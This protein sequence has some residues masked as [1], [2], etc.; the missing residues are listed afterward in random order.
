[1][2]NQSQVILPFEPN[3]IDVVSTKNRSLNAQH[4]GNVYYTELVQRLVA[5]LPLETENLMEMRKIAHDIV[6][7][8]VD[9]RGGR[10]LKPPDGV[11]NP[12]ECVEMDKR[13]A[14][15]KVLHAIRTAHIRNGKNARG[16][17]FSPKTIGV[18]KGKAKTAK[19]TEKKSSPAVP[20]KQTKVSSS[21]R[22]QGPMFRYEI[23]QEASESSFNIPIYTCR[24]IEAVCNQSTPQ[25]AHHVLDEPLK[26]TSVALEEGKDQQSETEEERSHRLDL[27]LRFA[28]AAAMDMAPLDF[29][30][31]LLKLWNAKLVLVKKDPPVPSPEAVEDGS[32]ST[33]GVTPIS[34]PLVSVEQSHQ[35]LG[36]SVTSSTGV[37]P[38][39]AGAAADAHL[40]SPSNPLAS[41]EGAPVLSPLAAAAPP[42]ITP[43]QLNGPPISS[44]EATTNSD[45]KDAEQQQQ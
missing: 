21:K 22:R 42:L 26:L 40:T 17:E 19:K 44:Q 7:H 18:G 1:M 28:G 36:A 38:K 24:L 20:P 4:P 23:V 29:A 39:A 13:Q 34:T 9:E 10:F 43:K 31:K 8:L 27:R 15:A 12:T 37:L 32:T 41:L 35:V 2:K 30:S 5:P 25:T 3:D 14:F 11:P 6:R 33:A 16:K 45:A